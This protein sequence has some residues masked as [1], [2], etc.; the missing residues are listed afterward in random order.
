MAIKITS[1]SKANSSDSILYVLSSLNQLSSISLPTGSKKYLKEKLDG[2]SRIAHVNCFNRFLLFYLTPT[3]KEND[4]KI[5]KARRYGSNIADF[6][7]K[8]KIETIFI[9]NKS[10]ANDYSLAL[11]EGI[12]LANYQFLKYKTGK[13]KKENP[14]RRIKLAPTSGS[15]KEVSELQNIVNAVFNA[16][17]LV[18]EPVIHMTAVQL[19]KEFKRMGRE[20]GFSVSVFNKK[21]IESLNM[22]GLLAVNYGSVIPPTFTVMEW[23]PKKVKNKKPIILVGKGVVYDTG[24][25]SLKPT[26]NSMD[27]M[28]CDMGGSAAVAGAMYLVAKNKLPLHVITL[29]PATDNRPGLNAYTPGD[30]IHMHN[31][32]TVEVLNTDAEGR[33]ILADALSYAKKWKPELVLDAATLT[34]SSVMAIANQ[35]VCMM[36]TAD[37]KTKTKLKESGSAV[38]ERVAELP[39]WEDYSDLLKSDIADIK[40]VGGRK[41]GAITAGKFLQNFIDYPWIHL[42]IAT[43]AWSYKK[44]SYRGKNGTGVGVRLFYDFLKRRA[45]K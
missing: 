22:G 45:L 39:F 40:N 9:D 42:D 26:S 32:M 29:V 28:K 24:G 18:N 14:L 12:S 23:K 13:F 4:K 35:G 7:N 38:H 44:D 33:M 37:E 17:N 43:M 20:A 34:G 41:A 16:R 8:N 31:G 10:K 21:K 30:V 36:G 25:L 15:R 27:H 3:K 5:E 2:E 1:A 6:C 11:A 19:A